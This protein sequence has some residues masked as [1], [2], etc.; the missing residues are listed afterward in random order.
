ME[1]IPEAEVIKFALDEK[2]K[3]SILAHSADLKIDIGF[4]YNTFKNLLNQSK[5]SISQIF[6]VFI[7]IGIQDSQ[8]KQ[9]LM[10]VASSPSINNYK[11][12]KL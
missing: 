5:C 3:D 11:T 1:K 2:E 7:A 8:L 12:K 4:N 10:N 9:L 6:S